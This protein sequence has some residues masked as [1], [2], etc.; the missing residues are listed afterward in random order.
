MPSYTQQMATINTIAQLGA[1]LR[2]VKI[3][4]WNTYV[5]ITL[6]KKKKRKCFDPLSYIKHVISKY[7]TLHGIN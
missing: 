5:A 2:D 7:S 1:S 4:S 3:I 6:R